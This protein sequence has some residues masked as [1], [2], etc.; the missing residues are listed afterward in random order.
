M[1]ALID[2]SILIAAERGDL[3]LGERLE[4]IPNEDLALSAITA[5]ELL[6]GVHRA[7]SEARR[8]RREAYVEALLSGFPV[9][10]FDLAAARTHARLTA[11]ILADGI[12]LGAHDLIIAASA[13]ARGLAVI[14]R[15]DRSFPRVPDLTVIR[16]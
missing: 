10:P 2:S 14:T 6:H 5:S 4:E 15:D 7:N 9:I 11:R 1:G 13:L 12:T 8:T 16:W 3:D